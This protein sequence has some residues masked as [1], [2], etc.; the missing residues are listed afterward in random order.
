MSRQSPEADGLSHTLSLG[1]RATVRGRI[2]G[3]AAGLAS[4]HGFSVEKT[5]MRPLSTP[6]SRLRRCRTARARGSTLQSEMSPMRMRVGSQRPPAPPEHSTGIS[7]F[8]HSISSATLVSM[9]SMQSTT[10]SGSPPSSSSSAPCSY[11]AFTASTSVSGQISRKC[12]ARA[13]TFDVPTS[14]RVATACRLSEDSVTWSKSMR[15][16]LPTPERRRRCAAWL[17][18]PPTPTTTTNAPAMARCPASPK[19]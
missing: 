10:Q 6:C 18:T 12:E 3:G 14:S 15:R 5:V 2:L 7:R 16:S 13:S 17:P 11:I 9:L 19:N 8:R 1:V 4:A